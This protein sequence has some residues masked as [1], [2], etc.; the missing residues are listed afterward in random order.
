MTVLYEVELGL[1]AGWI[2]M[3]RCKR[4]AVFNFES[5]ASSVDVA[6]QSSGFIGH[7]LGATKPV[8]E[9]NKLIIG[10]FHNVPGCG[11]DRLIPEV[12]MFV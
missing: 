5:S 3:F 9:F 1:V 12:D 6:N 7:F 11:A 4:D 10:Q 8:P 2:G